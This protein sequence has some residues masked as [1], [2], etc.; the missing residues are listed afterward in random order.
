[1]RASTMS[2]AR[3]ARGAGALSSSHD[4]APE[5]PVDSARADFR[6]FH[7]H[8]TQVVSDIR[9]EP[10]LK[11][12]Y[13]ERNP[14]ITN[15]QVMPDLS[16]HEVRP[17]TASLR[18][19]WRMPHLEAH[20]GLLFRVFH[21]GYARR[22]AR[23]LRRAR[24]NAA[25][26]NAPASDAARLDSDLSTNGT[27]AQAN[28]RQ[29]TFAHRGF[30]HVEGGWP[31]EVDPTEPE[32]V[33]R[34]RKK[35]ETDE[36][37][38]ASV[39]ALGAEVEDLVRQNNAVDIYEEYFAGTQADHSSEQPCAKTLTVFRDPCHIKRG[40]S[41]I[42]WNPDVE[43]RKCA[44]AYSILGFQQQPDEMRLSSYVW[45]VNA[46]NEPDFEL[47]GPSQLCCVNYNPKD[48]NVLSGGMYNGQVGY[49][50]ARKGRA[51]VDTSPIEKSHR[52][53]CYDMD[54]LQS[55][56]GTECFS[57][58][59]DGMVFWW[60]TRRLG[61]PVEELRL[62][63]KSN[64]DAVLG[65]VSVEYES[66]AG[67]TKFMI[68]TEQG[69]VLMC[70]RKAKHPAD[71]VG[72]SY[73]GHHG[74]VYS[75]KRNPFNPKYFMSIG[76][77]SARVWMEDLKTP[78]MTTR[79]HG[80]YLT[81]GTW[82]PTRP[83]VFFTIKA[84]GEMDVW[85]YYYK[86]DDP[87]LS[88]KV[89]EGTPLTSFNVQDTGRLVTVGAADGSATLMELCEGLYAP[90]PSEKQSVNQ[91]FDRETK[92]EKNLEAAA[93]DVRNAA[94]RAENRQ[95]EFKEVS[96]EAIAEMEKTFLNMTVKNGETFSDESPL[97]A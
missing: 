42:S 76:D 38:V 47:R 49:W 80:T 94:K 53:P 95:D 26:R 23:F 92:R 18:S 3:Y 79:Y 27:R 96:D 81:G 30:A 13:I 4:P 60:D 62:V 37:Y 97:G 56:T 70:N 36:A 75:L 31:K 69:T 59:T 9:P 68:G 34:Y 83:G 10:E 63:E 24:R 21:A 67:P 15:V 43:N 74:P 32:R 29:I 6:S 1:M 57:V 89:T 77:W 11:R 45:D 90:Q 91:M 71:R 14:V 40:A 61:E 12:D 20:D 73:H 48:T 64:P 78:I 84:D 7:A 28:T 82:S 72:T 25:R 33:I 86:Q 85:D 22:R 66:V 93:K 16:E 55:K 17:A 2:R 65:A 87:T 39:V 46:P 35:V 52:D 54:W 8:P 50:D 44:V 41:Y 5:S 58:S 88:V 19:R 51:P